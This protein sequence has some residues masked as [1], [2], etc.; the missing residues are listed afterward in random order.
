MPW[1]RLLA[2]RG[3]STAVEELVFPVRAEGR[4]GTSCRPNREAKTKSDRCPPM[5]VRVRM[6]LRIAA[7]VLREVN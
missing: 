7:E 2:R 6:A 4:T 1:I 5:K 3:V